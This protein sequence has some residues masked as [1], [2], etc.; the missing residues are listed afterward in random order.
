MCW[1][2]LQKVSIARQKWCMTKIDMTSKAKT[3]EGS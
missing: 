2:K 1:F 3:S